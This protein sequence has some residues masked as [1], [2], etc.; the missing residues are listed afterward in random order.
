MST[1]AEAPASPVVITPEHRRQWEEEGYFILERAIP[2]QQLDALRNECQRFIDV[3]NAEMDAEGVKVKGINHRDSRYFIA[4]RHKDSQVL[5]DFLFGPI[6]EQAVRATV[7]PDAYLFVDQFVVK[8][9]EVGMKFAWHRDSGYVGHA[10]APYLSA[11]VAMDDMSEANGTIY[12]LPYSRAGVRET[13]KH[14]KEAGSN[15]MIGY[16][17]DDP[18]VPVI[19][20]AGSVVCFSS[21]CFHR[22]GANTTKKP[23]RSYLCQY[24]PS[25]ILT[26]DGTKPWCDAVPFLKDGRNV[27]TWPA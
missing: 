18:G 2:P 12:V 8:M 20:P 17:G 13:V 21:N 9:A 25:P 23:R 24:S 14:T 11:W 15:D 27:F 16:H 22:S 10:H 19:V 5:R 26:R 4:R 1:L 3:I 6:M 7:G